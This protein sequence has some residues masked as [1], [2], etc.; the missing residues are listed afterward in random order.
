[1]ILDELANIIN[2]PCL[3]INYKNMGIMY[4]YSWFI[5]L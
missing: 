4:M 3:F 2:N 5:L 1:M